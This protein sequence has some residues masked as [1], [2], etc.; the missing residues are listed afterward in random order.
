MLRRGLATGARAGRLVRCA[1]AG[2][3]VLLVLLVEPVEVSVEVGQGDHPGRVLV[4][5]VIAVLPPDPG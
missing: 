4:A 1:A 5:A 3:G 2:H